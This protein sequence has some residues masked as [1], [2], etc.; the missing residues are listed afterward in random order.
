MEK[1]GRWPR[2]RA[3]TSTSFKCINLRSPGI[4]NLNLVFHVIKDAYLSR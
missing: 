1:D 2:A 3:P 4:L